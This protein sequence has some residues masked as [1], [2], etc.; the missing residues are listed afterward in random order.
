MKR[1]WLIP[2]LAIGAAVLVLGG[3]V[4]IVQ[5]VS[6]TSREISVFTRIT[7]QKS[8]FEMGAAFGGEEQDIDE[9]LES[10]FSLDEAAVLKGMPPDMTAAFS[11][12]N[13]EYE[14]GFELRYSADRARF[15]EIP[16]DEG[17]F[18][19]RIDPRGMWIPLS[20]GAA[21]GGEIDPT[22]AAFLGSSKYRLMIS[23]RL[24]S[25]ISSAYLET[26]EG[27]HDIT[28]SDLPDI[29]LLEFPVSLWFSSRS[30]PVVRVSF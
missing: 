9:M 21:E 8:I 30:A 12:V 14:Y 7:L 5:Y 13:T 20:D 26:A 16:D 10:E 11:P 28:V 4:D 17:M 18:V 25:R 27:V 15:A 22:G 29:W 1:R 6:G 3:C 19:P 23:K 2:I 24:V